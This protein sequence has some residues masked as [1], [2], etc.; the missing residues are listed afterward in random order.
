MYLSRLVVRNYRS[1]KEE[2][3][4]FTKGKNILVGKNNSG[5]SNI[6]LAIDLLLG[7]SSPTYAKSENITLADF[8]CWIEKDAEDKEVE[9]HAD[10]II[11]AG[12]L[13]REEDESLD[14]SHIDK[15]T[16]Y[17]RLVA[18][19]VWRPAFDFEDIR[20][21]VS[22]EFTDEDLERVFH[23][24]PEIEDS[25]L[26]GYLDKD[27]KQWV[28]SKLT[29]QVKFSS[30]LRNKSEFAFI[31]RA[32]KSEDNSIHKEIRFLYREH[33]GK[34][35]VLA[36]SAPVR[37]ELL[38]SA[39]IQ[40]FRDPQNQLRIAPY[41][42]YGKLM[43]ALTSGHGYADD[44]EKAKQGVKEVSDKIFL[45]AK[46]SVEKSSLS[47][48]FPNTEIFFQFNEEQKIDIYKDSKIYINDGTKGQLSE[49]GSGIQSATIIGL[50]NL[51]VTKYN[52]KTSALLCIEEPEIYLHPHARRV[53]SDKL[54]EFIESGDQVNHQVII[55]THSSEFIKTTDMDLNIL[56]IGKTKEEGTKVKTLD[57]GKF[58]KLLL[59][60]NY[61]EIFF[62]DKVILCEG[63]DYHIVKWIFNEVR[64]GVLNAKNISVIRVGGKDNLINFSELISSLNVTGY[65][66][67]DFDFLLRD[68]T[69]DAD[70]HK[71]V[72]ASGKTKSYRHRSL[73]NIDRTFLK[74]N[75]MDRTFYTEIIDLRNELKTNHEQ[76]FY[77]AKTSDEFPAAEVAKIRP[78]LAR[79]KG[80]GF[81]ILDGEIENLSKDHSL[82][83]PKT[84]KLS[85]NKVFEINSKLISG[86]K[87]SD[88]LEISS[89]TSFIDF[90]VRD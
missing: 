70:K 58:K 5:K 73:I 63:E 72:D 39:V 44:L 45:E 18:N 13:N 50:F 78:I 49:K 53:I 8:H 77:K 60:E 41:T 54:D 42:W 88:L 28:D 29:N 69:A 14:F 87:I 89:L 11:I 71:E 9:K 27:S 20:I 75:G 2:K 33:E 82:L 86:Q 16:G 12:I 57:V 51:F 46:K 19:K 56:L 22:K 81:C 74:K 3:I 40:S 61:N 64:P 32:K 6:L 84:I 37:N 80:V 76:L 79:L 31:F 21:T 4:N 30:E 52:S 35:W 62:A 90:V 23:Y 15:C 17:F 1:I 67:T 36:F 47:V 43:R 59:D 55:T 83:A 24:Q 65:L 25:T 10:E 68:D 66:F 26:P 34:D 48:A 85:L 7:E 38:Q